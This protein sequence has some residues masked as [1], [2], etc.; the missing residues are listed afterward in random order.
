[1]RILGKFRGSTGSLFVLQRRVGVFDM[2]LVGKW[3]W[4]MLVDKEGCGIKFLK[5]VMVR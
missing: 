2:A 4:R 5:P 1:V 3:C